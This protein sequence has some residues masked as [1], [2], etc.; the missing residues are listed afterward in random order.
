MSD[1]A[2]DKKLKEL[3]Q[4]NSFSPDYLN[5]LNSH[6]VHKPKELDEIGSALDAQYAKKNPSNTTPLEMRAKKSEEPEK[7]P[8]GRCEPYILADII[9]VS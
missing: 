6:D 7:I 4:Q 1:E 9:T 8:R 3:E 5:M 2:I